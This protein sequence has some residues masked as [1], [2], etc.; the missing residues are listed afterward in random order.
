M[1]GRIREVYYESGTD[2]NRFLEEVA[3][4][5]HIQ[6][7][8]VVAMTDRLSE[9][10]LLDAEYP[11]SADLMILAFESLSEDLRPYAVQLVD[12]FKEYCIG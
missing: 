4:V 3:K 9:L 6:K 8:Y 7:S 11:R 2:A 10:G 5:P 1:K 12:L